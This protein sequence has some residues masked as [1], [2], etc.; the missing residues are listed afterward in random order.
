M[1]VE[2]ALREL[3]QVNN[4]V[5]TQIVNEAMKPSIL[6]IYDHMREKIGYN[7][8][9]WYGDADV[10]VSI[11]YA[12]EK[13]RED[14]DVLIINNVVSCFDR[15]IVVAVINRETRHISLCKCVEGQGVKHESWNFGDHR[16]WTVEG[17]DTLRDHNW[18]FGY[19]D[20]RDESLVFQLDSIW[21]D[22]RPDKPYNG[23]HRS[24]YGCGFHVENL[25]YAERE[26]RWAYNSIVDDEAYTI[27]GEE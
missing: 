15:A 26:I 25:L 19:E 27:C 24:S 17:L 20:L 13:Y 3:N 1:N 2:L 18:K 22:I 10:Y 8:E 4:K 7:K 5:Y 12:F 21:A 11:E 16:D 9:I 14:H 6:A 23:W